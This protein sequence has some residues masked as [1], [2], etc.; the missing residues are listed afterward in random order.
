MERLTD[1]EGFEKMPFIKLCCMSNTGEGS[2]SRVFAKRNILNRDLNQSN[3]RQ[4]C[5]LLAIMAKLNPEP[6]KLVAVAIEAKL[7]CESTV[8]YRELIKDK[9]V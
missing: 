9:N 3:L 2:A 6:I 8:D 7:C 5:Q 1:G 4:T